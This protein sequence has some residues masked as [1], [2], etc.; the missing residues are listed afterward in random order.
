MPPS[1]RDLEVRVRRELRLAEVDGD[2]AEPGEHRAAAERLRAALE[3]DAVQD[4]DEPDLV[5]LGVPAGGKARF[6]RAADAN[7]PA[8]NPSL[9]ARSARRESHGRSVPP[10]I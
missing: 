10:R 2:P 9:K 6:R 3:L 5:A 7:I 1:R 4:R 8:Q